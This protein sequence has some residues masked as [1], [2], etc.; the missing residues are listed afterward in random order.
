MIPISRVKYTLVDEQGIEIFKI[1]EL[2]L[3]IERLRLKSRE[4]AYERMIVVHNDVCNALGLDPETVRGKLQEDEFVIC[5]Y[6]VMAIV[7]TYRTESK[8]YTY[9]FIGKFYNRDHAT[10]MY[11]LRSV[12]HEYEHN[13][14]VKNNLRLVMALCFDSDVRAIVKNILLGKYEKDVPYA[15][16]H[17]KRNN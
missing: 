15:N 8:K 12:Y 1:D 17:L 13:R 9:A 6:I 2:S 11:G 10:V 3:E 5:R 4:Q 16:Q 14:I 7:R